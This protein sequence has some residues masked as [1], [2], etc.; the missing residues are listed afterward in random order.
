[1]IITI[2]AMTTPYITKTTSGKIITQRSRERRGK[3]KKIYKSISRRKSRQISTN[4][5]NRLSPHKT[6]MP[7]QL[8]ILT[9]NEP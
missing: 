5:A 2:T 8:S 9:T 4:R 6:Y 1:M 7:L 3:N